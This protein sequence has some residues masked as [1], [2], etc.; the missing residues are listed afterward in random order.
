MSK[1]YP[2]IS[3]IIP[4]YNGAKN[5]K[6]AITSILNQ[7]YP[8]IEVIVVDDASKDNTVE[9][10][11]SMKDSRIKLLRHKENK[12]GAAARNTG[13][14]AAK[15]EYIAFLD[16]D[17]EWLPEKLM[18]QMQYLSTKDPNEWKA[19]LTGRSSITNG[20][21]KD[22]LFDREGDLRMTIYMMER[23]LGMGSSLLISKEAVDEVGFFNEKYYRNQDVEYILRYLRKYKLAVLPDHLVIGYGGSGTPSGD[24]LVEVKNL[25]LND[26]KKDIND[27]GPKQAKKIYARHWMQV[28]KNYSLEGNVSETLKYLK[29][30]LS[31]TVLFSNKVKFLPIAN[32]PAIFYYL[33]KSII[34]GKKSH[35]RFTVESKKNILIFA[36]CTDKKLKSKLLPILDSQ[37]VGKVFLVRN[38]LLNFSHPKLKQ[39][40]VIGIFRK[41]VPLR[42]L[43]RVLNGVGIL[44]GNKIDLVMGIHFVMHCIYAYFLAKLFRKKYAFLLIE[45]PEKYQGNKFFVK[46]L[47][48]AS[49][50]GIRGSNSRKYLVNLGAPEEKFFVA[51]NEF[52]LPKMDISKEKKTY[53]LIYMGNFVIEKDLPLW[54]D[55][56]EKVKEKLPNIKTVMLGDGVLFEDIKGRIAEKRLGENI[57]LVGRKEN[58]YDYVNKSKLNMMTSKTEG[59]PMVVVET[60]ACGVPSIVPNVGDISDLV[61]NNKNG[62]VVDSRNP[63]EF[64]KKIVELLSDNPAYIKMSKEAVKSIEEMA[65][66]TT[67]EVLVKTWEDVLEKHI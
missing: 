1:E 59:L 34:T 62:I 41:I 24:K 51:Q 31:Y 54:V 6:R 47:K 27:F 67:H 43:N 21:K 37:N 66:Q 38:T 30:S 56:V 7:T 3:V 36:G 55:V 64:A 22:G 10:V 61:K 32:Y 13:I 18:K 58:V 33:F 16:D 20:K 50:V 40:P 42:E 23:S 14:R 12:N 25:L 60:M 2:L 29:K 57:E 8:N 11:E 5:I 46:T 17:D 26:F 48:G 63:E 39:F 45:S 65:T 4:T 53:D 49:F 15:G 35:D 44:L 28:A 52:D 19:A 9:I